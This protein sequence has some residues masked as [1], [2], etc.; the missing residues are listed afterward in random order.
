MPGRRWAIVQHV[1]Y[2]GS[3]LIATLAR[4]RGLTLDVRRMDRGESLPELDGLAGLVVMGGPM[5]VHDGAEHDWL[6]RERELLAG[7]VARELSVLGV[8]LGSQ[9]L[10]AALG[11]RVHAGPQPE[12]GFGDVELTAEGRR[13]PV[14]GETRGRLPVMHWHAD[15]FE[16]PAGAVGLARSEHYANQAFRAGRRAYGLQFHVEL[17]RE[18][19][20][21]LRAHLPAGVTLDEERRVG[22]ERAGRAVL[23]RFF[24]IALGVN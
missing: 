8:C 6:E 24:D 16:L 7:A 17:D 20:D 12:I 1:A 5:G 4:A 22:V 10:A 11:A 15:T 3:G 14:L 18:L 23:A 9:Q 21:T 13:D 19:A 2:E